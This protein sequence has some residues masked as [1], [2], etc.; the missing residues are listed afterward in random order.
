MDKYQ[1]LTIDASANDQWHDWPPEV[2]SAS[3]R[4]SRLLEPG[5]ESSL[6]VNK[7]ANEAL[8]L[9]LL[10]GESLRRSPSST[11]QVSVNKSVL[12]MEQIKEFPECLFG[13]V[14]AGLSADPERDIRIQFRASAR[15]GV[16]VPPLSLSKVLLLPLKAGRFSIRWTSWG[17]ALRS[18]ISGKRGMGWHPADF[19]YSHFDGLGYLL[20]HHEARTAVLSGRYRT[21]FHYF[22]AEGRLKN[23]PLR[24][25]VDRPP[26]PGTAF[27]LV[28]HHSHQ[29][30]H[31]SGRLARTERELSEKSEQTS[32]DAARAKADVDRLNGELADVREEN[33]LILLQLHQVQEELE[34]YFLENRDLQESQKKLKELEATNES[35]T[36]ERDALHTK[37]TELEKVH[38]DLVTRH[39]A[40]VSAL[41]E[42]QGQHSSLATER[43]AAAK[44]REELNAKVANLEKSRQ[45]AADSRDTTIKERDQARAERD[46]VLKERDALKK[47]VSDRA[48]RIAELEAQ[49]ADQA[50]RQ[51]QIDEEM[52]KAEGQLEMLKELLRPALT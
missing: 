11:L 15:S 21:A 40:L 4:I 27:N 19:P 32:K 39:S 46:N 18:L 52:A 48:M 45:D 16:S 36:R 35:A 12:R 50:E 10:V 47:T 13:V 5:Q 1:A 6:V 37:L 22:M 17:R 34:H 20:E 28:S 9:V 3:G 26:V 7:A 41:E 49:I 38:H 14:P 43:D 33:E 42:L 24:L 23:H 51:K 29:A 44:E 25:A 30:D 2:T 31:F 8:L